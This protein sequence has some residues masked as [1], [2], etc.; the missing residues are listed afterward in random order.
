MLLFVA[1]P[2][3]AGDGD[4]S[5]GGKNEPLRLDY[6]VPTD[7]ASNVAVKTDI[8][9][10]FTKNVVYMTV[11]DANSKSFSLSTAEGKPVPFE[12]LM[13]DDQIE[14]EK[15]RIVVI[16]PRNELIP[17]TDYQLTI[18][19]EFK[20]KSGVTL[21]KKVELSFQ[22]IPGVKLV[23]AQPAANAPKSHTVPKEKPGQATGVSNQTQTGKALPVV[24][25]GDGKEKIQVRDSATQLIKEG[26]GKQKTKTNKKIDK[27]GSKVVNKTMNT[28][29]KTKRGFWQSI[30]DWF[31]NL[32]S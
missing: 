6:S 5:G 26:P 1:I 10:T 7:G 30:V 13:A 15:K 9:L 2:A 20:A 3:L 31:S 21:G 25:S 14:P 18:A 29:E 11:R 32:F 28:G 12:V 27:A 8:T 4:G 19:P 16:H 24:Q 17:G 22:T 23:D